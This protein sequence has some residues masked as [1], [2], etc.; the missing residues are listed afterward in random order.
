[1]QPPIAMVWLTLLCVGSLISAAIGDLK[2]AGPIQ[3]ANA[4]I[5]DPK[6]LYVWEY[7][8]PIDWEAV[9]GTGVTAT[10]ITWLLNVRDRLTV[11]RQRPL[12][13]DLMVCSI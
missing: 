11:T 4:S 7:D 13:G 8:G 12:G 1:M 2:A 9:S 5:S 10:M 3:A 6:L